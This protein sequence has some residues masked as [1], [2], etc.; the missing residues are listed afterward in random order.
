M[1]Y[2]SGDGMPR[3]FDRNMFIMLLAIMIGAII[4]T[5][6]IADIQYSS[7][8]QTISMQHTTQIQD[9]NS[10][11]ENFTDNF[12]QGSVTID[13][14]REIRE[15][16]NYHFDFALFWFNNALNDA[17]VWFSKQWI[18][19]TQNLISLCISNC[20]VAMSTYLNSYE[21]FGLSQPYF[22]LAK[23]YT[24]ITKYVEVLGYY[25]SFADAGQNITLLRYN[26]SKYLRQA[27]ENLSLGNLDN[28][29]MNYGLFNDTIVAYGGASGGYEE[30]KKQIDGYLF[31][32]EI[33]EVPDKP[34]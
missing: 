19:D 27:A 17:N 28:F 3:I 22:T 32:S 16:A 13:S 18:N 23:T 30:K 20:T 29:S 6:F 4:I 24:N 11:N 8:L 25:N 14:A 2:Q 26:A 21:K 5:Y 34:Q 33:R 9:I 1:L 7:D 15:I 10:N 31:I 12:L